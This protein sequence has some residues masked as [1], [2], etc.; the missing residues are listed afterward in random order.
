[1]N[2]T[3]EAYAAIAAVAAAIAAWLSFLQQRRSHL[4]QTAPELVLADFDADLTGPQ[5]RVSVRTIQNI[6]E[7]PASHVFMTFYATSRWAGAVAF[8]GA[9]PVPIIASGRAVTTDGHAEIPRPSAADRVGLRKLEIAVC[10]WDTNNRRHDFIHEFYL[11]QG[12]LGG[13]Q[14]VAPG[15]YLCRRYR[16]IRSVY[17]LRLGSAWQRARDRLRQ[18]TRV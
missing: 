4:A 1:L 9:T 10:G 12:A 16:R 2:S 14:T 15:L 6:G 7:G 5:W 18:L 3:A 13:C 17:A 11:T 8:G